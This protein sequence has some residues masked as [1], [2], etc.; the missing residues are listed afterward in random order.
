MSLLKEYQRRRKKVFLAVCQQLS[1]IIQYSA[2]VCLQLYIKKMLQILILPINC[3]VIVVNEN[4]CW[5]INEKYFNFLRLDWPHTPRGCM[6]IRWF[7]FF[8]KSNDL[9]FLKMEK[10]VKLFVIHWWYN[11]IASHEI[12]R[13]SQI[14]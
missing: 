8:N 7:P 13:V 9:T 3:D 11:N 1:F 6:I 12:S 2:Y 5:S 10:K 4:L 14:K